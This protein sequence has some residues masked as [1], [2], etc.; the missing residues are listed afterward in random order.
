MEG[1]VS[2]GHNG[3]VVVVYVQVFDTQLIY[4]CDDYLLK[5]YVK[6]RVENNE[7]IVGS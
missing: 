4:T 6:F 5:I 2:F 7:S 3:I 1:G